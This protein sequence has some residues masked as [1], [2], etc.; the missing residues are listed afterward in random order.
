MKDIML[1][2]E[3]S[4][5]GSPEEAIEFVTEGKLSSRGNTTVIK[6]EESPLAGME[7]CT[8]YLTIS[9]KKVKLKRTGEM[10]PI[11][12][13]MEFEEGKRFTGMYETQFGAVG[14]E[15]LTNRINQGPEV[16]G[17]SKLSID[18]SLSLKGLTESRNKL[19]ITIRNK[20]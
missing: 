3:G 6:Y 1:K 5:A 17:E 12:T 19:D 4:P 8:T 7:G 2:I 18:Y 16:C 9:P 14:M 11:P 13:V 10:F 15:I 20:Q